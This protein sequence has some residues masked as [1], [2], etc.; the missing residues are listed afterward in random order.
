[1]KP[2]PTWKILGRRAAAF[3]LIGAGLY[4]VLMAPLEYGFSPH[5]IV[6]GFLGV[7]MVVAG[8][9]AWIYKDSP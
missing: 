1:M 6:T 2:E 8:R 9:Y 4:T 3:Y 7:L 5:G